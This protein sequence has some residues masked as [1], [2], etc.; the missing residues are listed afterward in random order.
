MCTQVELNQ[1]LSKV[2]ALYHK[3]YGENICSI[4]LYGSYARR[5]FDS[6]SDIDIVAIV[7]GTR[8]ELQKQLEQ[9]WDKSADIG[10]DY[11]VIISPTVIPYREFENYKDILPYYQNILKEG[12]E[13]SA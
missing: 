7:K 12:V 5:D 3:T 6:D 13:I 4:Y 8:K 10:L 2:I 9:I 1:I 11:E